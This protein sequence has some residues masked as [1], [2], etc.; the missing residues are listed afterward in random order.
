MVLLAIAD[1]DVDAVF[2]NVVIFNFF[3]SIH[4]RVQDRT[5]ESTEDIQHD[6]TQH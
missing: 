4:G 5:R 1:F 3:F 2:L 6:S